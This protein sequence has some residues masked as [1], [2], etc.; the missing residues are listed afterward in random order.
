MPVDGTAQTEKVVT[1]NMN[2]DGGDNKCS[3]EGVSQMRAVNQ[4]SDNIV[5]ELCKNRHD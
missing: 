4:R 2:V 5:T 3:V 1:K